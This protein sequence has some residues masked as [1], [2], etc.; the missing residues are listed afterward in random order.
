ML[1]IL[2]LGAIFVQMNEVIT[3]NLELNINMYICPLIFKL[4]ITKK[5]IL[6]EKEL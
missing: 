2:G 1:G 4:C 5:L 6:K 3:Y